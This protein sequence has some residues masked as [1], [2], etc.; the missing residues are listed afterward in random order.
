MLKLLI[1][2]NNT[3]IHLAHPPLSAELY[4]AKFKMGYGL[5]QSDTIAKEILLP[6]SDTELLTIKETQ[7]F[8]IKVPYY[9]LSQ[10]LQY[11]SE[12]SGRK[13]VY[14]KYLEKIKA[15]T[16]IN[17]QNLFND[18]TILQE[19]SLPL[20]SEGIFIDFKKNILKSCKYHLFDTQKNGYISHIHCYEIIDHPAVCAGNN[21][22][23]YMHNNETIH[24]YFT[25]LY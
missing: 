25:K 1:P 3:V 22:L 13:E 8:I 11:Y 17:V 12:R 7:S 23:Y 9:F 18:E 10:W 5:F 2:Q 24:S 14:I 20:S 6:K 4:K 19:K 21:T 15:L 16:Y